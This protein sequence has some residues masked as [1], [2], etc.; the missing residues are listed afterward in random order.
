MATAIKSLLLTTPSPLASAF[1]SWAA[2]PKS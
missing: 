1:G 2:R